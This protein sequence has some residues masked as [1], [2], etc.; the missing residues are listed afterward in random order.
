MLLIVSCEFS[1]IVAKRIEKTM[2]YELISKP[3]DSEIAK[4]GPRDNVFGF[5]DLLKAHQRYWAKQE[6]DAHDTWDMVR[7]TVSEVFNKEFFLSSALMTLSKISHGAASSRGAEYARRESIGMLGMSII[8]RRLMKPDINFRDGFGLGEDDVGEAWL[9]D[10]AEDKGDMPGD[11]R[12]HLPTEVVSNLVGGWPNDEPEAWY[13][14]TA[15]SCSG[16]DPRS[17]PIRLLK[18]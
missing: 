14:G 4:Y 17:H 10:I 18:D 6:R 1:G 5:L 11:H 2:A 9:F 3:D 8:M 12:L 15:F 16:Y 13:E 7:G